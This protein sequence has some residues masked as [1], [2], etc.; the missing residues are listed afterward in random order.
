MK[1]VILITFSLLTAFAF[2]QEQKKDTVQI[3][4]VTIQVTKS[5]TKLQKMPMAISHISARDIERLGVNDLSD[6]NGFIPNL[7]MPDYGSRLTSPIYIRGIGSRINEPSVGL[8]VDDIPYFDKGSFNFEFQN[9]KKIEVL[10]GP[11][12]TLYGRNTMGGLIR[13]YTPEPKFKNGASFRI[14]YATNNYIKPSFHIN[15]VLSDKVAFLV[16]ASLVRTDGF[17]TNKFTGKKA[18][19]S[20]T[21]SAR[22][23]LKYNASE[24]LKFNFSANY[25]KDQQDGYP[26]A[27]YNTN[28]QTIGEVNYNQD[29]AYDRDLYAL[30]FNAKYNASPFDISFSASYQGMEDIQLIDQ[31]FLAS[32]IYYVDQTRTKNTFVEE[33]NFNSKKG[34]KIK[35]IA[36]LFAFQASSDKAVDVDIYPAHMTLFKTYDQPTNGLAAFGQVEIPYNK[37]KFTLGLRYDYEKTSL[38]YGYDRA[39]GGNRSNVSNLDLTLS[40]NELLPKL[41]VNYELSNTANI[42][43]S[44][45]KGYKAGGFNATIEREEDESYLPEY[46]LNYEIG[47]KTQWLAKKLTANAS[48]FYIDWKDQQIYQTVPSGH[49]S[50][51][52][53]AGKSISQGAELELAYKI[54]NTLDFGFGFGY[55]DA[56]FDDYKRDDTLDYSGN[57]I[58]FIPKYTF[59]TQGNYHLYLNNSKLQ[60]IIINANYKHFGK[61]YWNDANESYQDAYGLLNANITAKYE[62]LSFG[63]WAKNA[64]DAN[65]NSHFFSIATL[66]K[67]YA[68]QGTPAQLGVFFKYKL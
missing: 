19:K 49:G 15:Q 48:V 50:M 66:H 4:D 38:L 35:W 16:D 46:S 64:L 43:G 60:Q 20:L 9:I 62:K 8:Y 65:Y 63:I 55:T 6:L 29:S 1:K 32:S 39:I 13:V 26:Y 57:Y 44:F 2:A 45:S 41:I 25:E 27:V 24:K 54:N 68:Q 53:N 30:G 31:D 14:D 17:F 42:Y 47:A 56:K 12:G 67:S 34:S 61:S 22:F 3:E 11:Q 28:T 59:N 37:F 51:L 5:N 36:G 23:K 7:F 18:D 33:L 52:K 21:Q 10:R 40:Y 58:P